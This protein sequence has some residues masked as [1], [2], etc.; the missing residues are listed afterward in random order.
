VFEILN[1]HKSKKK[2]K[3][4]NK[5]KNITFD[6]NEVRQTRWRKIKF[7]VSKCVIIVSELRVC[8]YNTKPSTKCGVLIY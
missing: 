7:K 8:I 1:Q 3:I 4:L 2:T 6:F 5:I